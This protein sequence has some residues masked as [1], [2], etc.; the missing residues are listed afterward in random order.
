MPDDLRERKRLTAMRRVQEQAVALF[1]ARGFADVTVEEIA[2][3]AEVAPVSVYRWFG[4][5]EGLVLWDDYDPDLFAAIAG[6]LEDHPPLSAVRDAV[7]AELGRIYDA[8][9][10]LVLDRTKLI[11]REPALLAAA[12]VGLRAMQDALA[13]LFR[14]AT[15][16]ELARRVLAGA[17]VSTLAAAIEAWQADDGRTPLATF[18]AQGFDVLEAAG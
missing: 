7:V 1:G 9:R 2:R 11:H 14:T 12:T 13:E 16:D 4:T 3:A 10:A 15:P 5:K 6:H 8:D 17:A 18:V